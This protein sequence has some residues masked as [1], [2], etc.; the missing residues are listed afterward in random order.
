MSLGS[1]L[2]PFATSAASKAAPALAAGALS[3]LGSLG[4]DK[5]FGRVQTGG[6]LIPQDKI[7]KL[8]QHKNLLT[9]KQK[10]EILNSLQSGGQL[11]LKTYKKTK[12]WVSWD[13]IS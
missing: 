5:S 12:R 10:E 2:L 13:L 7:D 1:K 6:F 9:K 8:I 11:G 4:I 3:S